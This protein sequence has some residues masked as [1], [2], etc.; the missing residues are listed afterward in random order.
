MKTKDIKIVAATA[1]EDVGGQHLY[2][3]TTVP[4]AVQPQH[5]R[6]TSE[7]STPYSKKKQVL[8]TFCATLGCFLNG[9]V[10]GYSAP[11]I[12][13]LMNPE[14]TDLYGNPFTLDS[15][16]ASWITGILSLGCFFGCIVAGPI[17]EKIGRKK[18]LLFFTSSCF[19]LGYLAIFMANT[20]SLIYI[21]RFLGG[22]GLGFEL[23]VATVYI[24]E[25]AST[26]MRGILGCFV[27]FMGS[28][29]VLFTF[30]LGSYLNWYW[31]A[32]VNGLTVIFFVIGMI[33]VPESPRWLILK[34]KEFSAS[35]SLEWLRG[36]ENAQAEQAV[37]REIEKIKRDIAAKKKERVSLTQLRTAWK[38]FLVSLGMMFLLQFSALN[39][40]VYYAVSIFQISSIAIDPN[41]A[42]VIVGITLLVSCM[43]AL[44]VVSRLN[45]KIMLVAS[46]LT[47]GICHIVLQ[48][49]SM[50][51]KTSYVHKR[52]VTA[53]E[54]KQPL[55]S[56]K[57]LP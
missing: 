2:R 52:K 4:L 44:A 51:K 54:A 32:M 19:L 18:T 43:V 40:I 35:K 39:V 55:K 41:L 29:G 31:L 33:C 53:S 46:I 20:V 23:A 17:M 49:A 3:D 34:G 30:I 45:R 48:F 13:S 11:A 15:Q 12:P 10:I 1:S 36:R 50:F 21:G 47:M 38:P 42:S 28:I 16:Q 56:K 5:I 22:M 57:V 27:Q 14:G 37:D 24:V 25:I 9:T 6:D 8:A 7:V 26:D